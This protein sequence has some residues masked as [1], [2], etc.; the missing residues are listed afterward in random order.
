VRTGR[1]PLGSPHGE[2]SQTGEQG[3]QG[4]A[5]N[6]TEMNE[7]PAEDWRSAASSVW[8]S[9]PKGSVWRQG[10]TPEQWTSRMA[11]EAAERQGQADSGGSMVHVAQH[12]A[13]GD[14][15]LAAFHPVSKVTDCCRSE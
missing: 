2:A 11:L 15:E 14:R 7:L 8:L 13:Q 3:G 1:D 9:Q 4:G 10:L 5:V 6:H 12:A